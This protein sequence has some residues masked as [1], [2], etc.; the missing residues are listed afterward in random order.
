MIK[1][2][3]KSKGVI[4][5]KIWSKLFWINHKKYDQRLGELIIFAITYKTTGKYKVE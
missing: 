4:T 1:T 5:F 3:R 2:S